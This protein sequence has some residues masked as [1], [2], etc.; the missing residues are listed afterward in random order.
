MSFGEKLKEYREYKSMTQ[1][2]LANKIGVAKSTIAGY[3]KG[4]RTPDVKKIKKL[5]DALGITG[6]DLLETNTIKRASSMSEEAKQL[7]ETYDRLDQWGKR[8][9]WNT[10]QHELARTQDESRFVSMVEEEKPQKVIPIFLSAPAAGLAAPI[11]GEDY[12][13]YV[14]QPEDPQG[15]LFAVRVSG[16]SMEP[17]FPDGSIVFCNKDPM[18]GGD[19]GV[20]SVDGESLIKQYYRDPLGMVYLFSLNRSRSDAD[21]VLTRDCGR[22]L[23]CLGR[24]ITNR[25]FDLPL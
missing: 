1:E 23:V 7:G 11:V 9:V 13:D 20:F 18:R 22:S 10:A 17:Y 3:E 15:A 2:Q 14:L 25:R 5:A 21:V 6:D 16:D 8:L 4:N 19:I 12:D 24:V